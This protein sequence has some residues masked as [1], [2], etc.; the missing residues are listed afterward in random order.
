MI[1]LKYLS[2]KEGN[3]ALTQSKTGDWIFQTVIYDF[4]GSRG[5]GLVGVICGS[6]DGCS[7]A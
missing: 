1:T 7:T 5:N 6:T 2:V 3:V 4:S